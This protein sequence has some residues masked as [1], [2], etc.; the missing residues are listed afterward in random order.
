MIRLFHYVSLL[1]LGANLTALLSLIVRTYAKFMP[2][3][4]SLVGLTIL[5]SGIAILVALNAGNH[6]ASVPLP[7]F[8]S[9]SVILISIL[10]GGGLGW[11]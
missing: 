11:L 3:Y 7:V 4:F 1:G 2:A 6:G 5:I 9:A 8:F 10:L